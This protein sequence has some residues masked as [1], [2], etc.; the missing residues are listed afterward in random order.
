MKISDIVDYLIELERSGFT[1]A[2]TLN[3]HRGDVSSRVERKVI[4]KI[5]KELTTII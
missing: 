3:F 1:G 2:V 4:E 5:E